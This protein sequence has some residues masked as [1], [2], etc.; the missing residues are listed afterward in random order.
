MLGKLPYLCAAISNSSIQLIDR[1]EIFY[2]P[3]IGTV[4][5]PLAAVNGSMNIIEAAGYAMPQFMCQLHPFVFLGMKFV[6]IY[7][8]VAESFV[9]HHG[10]CF[11]IFKVKAVYLNI[12]FICNLVEL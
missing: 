6:W 8:D 7:G 9:V 2:C 1:Y 3:L 11:P 4:F 12:F 10:N 5:M